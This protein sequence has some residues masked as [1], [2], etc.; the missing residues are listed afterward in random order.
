MTLRTLHLL[1]QPAVISP[2]SMALHHHSRILAPR[3]RNVFSKPEDHPIYLYH[4]LCL[5]PQSA[6]VIAFSVVFANGDP[7]LGL[8]SLSGDAGVLCDVEAN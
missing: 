7:N 2:S 6:V 5:V 8:P 1:S 4:V 3:S